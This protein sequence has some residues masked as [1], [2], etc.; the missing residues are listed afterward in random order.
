MKRFLIG[1]ILLWL[2]GTLQLQAQNRLNTGSNMDQYG[3]Q[4]DPSRQLGSL[5][6]DSID[7][8]S[9][10]PK[11]FMWRIDELLGNSTKVEVDT[12]ALNY[13]NLNHLTEGPTGH[14]NHLGNLGS[15]RLS[16]LFRERDYDTETQL[17][18]QP[19]AGFFFKRAGEMNFTNSNIPYT[20]LTYNPAGDK[21]TGE[22]RF[23]AY[24]SANVNKRFAF[25]FNF[26]YL[27]GRGN[28]SNQGT[29]FFNGGLFASYKGDH[30]EMHAM[31]Q[32][33]YFK[34]NENG[35][36]TNDEYI[37]HPENMAEGKKEYEPNNIP[38][39]LETTANRN[40]NFTLFLTHRYRIGFDKRIVIHKDGG[41]GEG[42]SD[43]T[44][45]NDSQSSNGTQRETPAAPAN[46]PAP[47]A[48]P[49]RDNNVKPSLQPQRT[50][51]MAL[52]DSIPP[53]LNDSI[54]PVLNDSIAPVLNDSIAPLLNDS[55]APLS[56]DSIPA[57]LAAPEE[58]L[59][60]GD[61]VIYEFVPVTSFIHTLRV[62]RS[63]HTFNSNDDLRMD[64]P[65]S[66]YNNSASQDSTIALS[67]KNVLGVALLEGFNKYAK[68]GLTAYISHKLSHYTLMNSDT[69]L[70]NPRNQ[71]YNEQEVY[72]GGE[73]AKREGS[74]LHYNITGEFGIMDKAAGQF[75]LNGNADLNIPFMRDSLRFYAR[76]RISN[77]L[78][79]FYMRHYHS[80]HFTWD[81]DDMSKEFRIRLEAEVDNPAT[82]TN[83]RAGFETV[84]NYTYFDSSALPAQWGENISVAD[85]TLTQN[86]RVGIFHLDNEVTWQKS[87]N[88][89]VLP[90]PTF[91]FYHNFYL[92]TKIAKQVL[93]LQLGAD[94]RYFTKYNAPT[95]QPA[96][97]QF[98][99]QDQETAVEI[100]GFPVVNVYANFQLKRTR[101]F[102]MYHHLN[103]GSG[104]KNYFLAP[105]YPM[106]QSWL[107]FG[108]S[109]NFYD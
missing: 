24:F 44:E 102:V 48:Q 32:N 36:I 75:R 47:Q 3:N 17:F 83:L 2:V 81:N 105:H 53:V 61:S 41:N 78:P 100:G 33:F 94:V 39:N 69:T 38:V 46:T 104:K 42:A 76:A 26:D 11:L 16:R 57:P 92:L 13:Q 73:L 56:N 25:G 107:K 79:T 98:H 88:Q 54:A 28:Y 89:E 34:Q 99:L 96:I 77:T 27:Y 15:P 20:N 9:L 50:G 71:T 22:D 97:E 90:L 19:Y 85:V 12:V 60:E 95:Y 82:G 40:H 109:W 87:S 55:I 86:F 49:R 106:N 108:V 45:G 59:A 18:L 63:R 51:M 70:L 103:A 43:S 74:L 4:M 30:Y 7:I 5:G 8:E 1:V 62:E 67:V 6:N 58:A 84:K 68:A 93:T 66:L 101:F 29:S 52:N 14:Y 80:N 21:V 72:V 91:N 65:I 23:K 10:P 64:F 31:Y 35:G 37:T